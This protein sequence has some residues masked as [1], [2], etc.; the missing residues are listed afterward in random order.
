MLELLDFLNK[1]CWA[2]LRIS[3]AYYG[4]KHI[5]EKYLYDQTYQIVMKYDNR[6]VNCHSKN[7]STFESMIVG[8]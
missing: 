6:Y 5:M 7:P 2:T 1:G 4:I 8:R 3:I